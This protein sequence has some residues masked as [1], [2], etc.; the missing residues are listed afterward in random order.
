MIKIKISTRIVFLIG[1]YAIKMPIDLRGYYQGL[2]EKYLYNKYRN[3]GLLAKLI[4]SKLGIVVQ[5]RVDPIKSDKINP[6]LVLKIKSEIPELNISNCDL[7]NPVNWGIYKNQT[8]LLDYGITEK[9][10]IMY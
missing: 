1:N 8:V 3:S 7:H 5:Q 2:N 4:W 6:I 9:V 10:S